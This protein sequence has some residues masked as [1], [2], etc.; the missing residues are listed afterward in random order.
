MKTFLRSIDKLFQVEFNLLPMLNQNFLWW[1]LQT[2]SWKFHFLQL[3][4]KRQIRRESVKQIVLNQ[5]NLKE[6]DQFWLQLWL[7]LK[8]LKLP[9]T[10]CGAVSFGISITLL[11]LRSSHW[12]FGIWV[13]TKLGRIFNPRPLRY[14]PQRFELIFKILFSFNWVRFV[15]NRNLTQI[16]LKS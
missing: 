14:N 13:N 2:I 10:C 16:K 3:P 9:S 7:W 6:K 11:S 1:K 12:R 15:T 5:E 8:M 4:D